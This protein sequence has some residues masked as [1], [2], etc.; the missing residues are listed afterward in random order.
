LDYRLETNKVCTRLAGERDYCPPHVYPPQPDRLYRNLHNGTF[1]DV[2]SKALAGGEFGPALGVSTADFNG[3]GW[4]DIYVANDNRQNLL[5]INQRNGTLKNTA[6][7]AGAALPSTGKPEASMGV[8]AG[9]F[10]ND[11]DEDLFVTELTGEG[12]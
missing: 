12:H 1:E 5:W 3:D 8:D 10:D 6:L 2:T 9:D 7:G 4:M 11:G